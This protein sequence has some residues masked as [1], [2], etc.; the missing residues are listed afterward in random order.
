MVTKVVVGALLAGLTL[1]GAMHLRLTDSIPK[2]ETSVSES[3]GEIRVWFNQQP[4]LPVSRLGL[5]GPAG[6]IELGRAEDAEGMSFTS[7]VQDTLGAGEYT[8]SW[9]TAGDDGH[10]RRG[11]FTFT[12]SAGEGH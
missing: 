4:Q 8:V 9:R 6:E 7:A 1:S 12:V 2:A 5:A 11:N 3:P 10:V